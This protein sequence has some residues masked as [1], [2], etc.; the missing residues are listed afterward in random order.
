MPESAGRAFQAVE[1]AS[2]MALRPVVFAELHGDQCGTKAGTRRESSRR[3]VRMCGLG[4]CQLVR[5]VTPD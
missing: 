1:T 4:L 5:A 2:A 3:G